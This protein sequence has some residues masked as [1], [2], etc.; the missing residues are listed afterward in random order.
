MGFVGEIMSGVDYYSKK[1]S[2]DVLNTDKFS[3]E[4]SEKSSDNG[5][6]F[7]STFGDD[8][9]NIGMYYPKYV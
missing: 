7:K 9:K 6:I 1:Y 5:T 3:A 4:K 2:T 8:C